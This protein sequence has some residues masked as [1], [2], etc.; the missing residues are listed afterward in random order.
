MLDS[1]DFPRSGR[2]IQA[3]VAVANVFSSARRNTAK[4]T[5][6][7]PVRQADSKPCCRQQGA[8]SYVLR[9]PQAQ[10]LGGQKS[11]K[12]SVIWC[13][14]EW[15]YLMKGFCSLSGNLRITLLS[16]VLVT[17]FHKN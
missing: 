12:K 14:P 11:R 10:A 7:P 1:S 4:T 13:P 9:L 6:T 2:E 5:L 15:H 17:V 8:M 3:N 16:R